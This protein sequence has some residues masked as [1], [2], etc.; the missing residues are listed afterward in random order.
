MIDGKFWLSGI[1]EIKFNVIEIFSVMQCTAIFIRLNETRHFKKKKKRNRRKQAFMLCLQFQHIAII[2]RHFNGQTIK[3]LYNFK[4]KKERKNSSEYHSSHKS[5]CTVHQLIFF[6]LYASHTRNLAP[7][8]IPA[9]FHLDAFGNFNC[10]LLKCD[11][12]RQK[13]TN[14]AIL[15]HLTIRLISYYKIIY[16]A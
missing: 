11:Y 16:L 1:E 9:N 14:S 15:N 3:Q 5:N 2:I 8:P 4:P 6:V 13:S 7:Y 10:M 12:K